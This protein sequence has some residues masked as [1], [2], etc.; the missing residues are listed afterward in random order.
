MKRLIL[1]FTAAVLALAAP[2]AYAA[3]SPAPSPA[4]TACPHH[5]EVS[6]VKQATC[7]D[8]GLLAYTCAKCGLTYTAE[9]LPTGQHD[10]VQSDST[11]TCTEDGQ[12]TYT[13]SVC[14]ESYTEPVQAPGHVP[15]REAPDCDAAVVCT[16]C[17]QVLIPAPGHD[18]RYQYDAVRAPDGS[19]SDYGTWLCAN[20]G[21][22]LAATKGN[23]EFYYSLLDEPAS[24]S[25]EQSEPE[26]SP[27][28]EPSPE[29]EEDQ[30]GTDPH[31]GLW[32]GLGVLVLAAVAA[33][34]VVLTRSLAKKNGDR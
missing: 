14:G 30:S 7:V 5:F 22:T 32:I 18:Y 29:P 33:E 26:A 15:D 17:G 13:C 34:A 27:S 25:P 2:A 21:R 1:L 24:S 31:T 28:P 10:Y 3:P 6:V 11:V 23:A 12:I 19:F 20:C 9:T 4:P 8:K 16:V